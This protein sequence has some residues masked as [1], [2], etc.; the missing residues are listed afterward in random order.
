[1]AIPSTGSKNWLGNT[2]DQE[3]GRALLPGLAVAE[4]DA[5]GLWN[6]PNMM[7]ARNRASIPREADSS[8]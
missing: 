7:N 2:R 8:T 5:R 4:A 3:I 6:D 1:M